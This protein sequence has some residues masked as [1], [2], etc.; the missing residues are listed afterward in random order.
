MPRGRP[1]KLCVDKMTPAETA[2]EFAYL[3]GERLGMICA[4]RPETRQE[5]EQAE[6]E[7][8]EMLERMT[9]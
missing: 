5:R 4:D 1:L 8:G 7:A 2:E 6:R 3:T 9:E